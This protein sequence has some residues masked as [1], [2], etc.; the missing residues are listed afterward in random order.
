ML[1]SLV[2]EMWDE[3]GGATESASSPLPAAPD[4]AAVRP[5]ARVSSPTANRLEI[6]SWLPPTVQ[7]ADE[8]LVVLNTLV[9]ELLQAG[10]G[11]AT[12]GRPNQL[13][14]VQRG[15]RS[16]TRVSSP[17]ANPQSQVAD[18]YGS[19]VPATESRT[20][21]VSPSSQAA[22]ADRR[23]AGLGRPAAPQIPLDPDDLAELVNQALVEQALRH[24]VDLL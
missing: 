15:N 9:D 21:M 16:P 20:G 22:T 14:R 23:P 17:A 19:S 4:A 13:D 5:P 24:G 2:A 3:T 6:E 7:S 8:G 11:A 18:R 1:D 12:G 10:E